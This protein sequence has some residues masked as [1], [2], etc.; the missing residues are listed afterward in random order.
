MSTPYRPPRSVWS[1]AGS[2]A[3]TASSVPWRGMMTSESVLTSRLERSQRRSRRGARSSSIRRRSRGPSTPGKATR[4]AKAQ[5]PAA[6]VSYQRHAIGHGDP[7]PTSSMPSARLASGPA[8]GHRQSRTDCPMS[9]AQ[10]PAYGPVVGGRFTLRRWSF[11]SDSHF[12]FCVRSWSLVIGRSRGRAMRQPALPAQGARKGRA[13]CGVRARAVSPRRYRR[14]RRR[15][16]SAPTPPPRPGQ[17]SATR[18]RAQSR[19]R[20]RARC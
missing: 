14:P 4:V 3:G 15:R 5:S 11:K 12:R 7:S 20:R 1:P 18:H 8:R 6:T 16:T 9:C 2:P 10:G 17:T 19:S 13:R